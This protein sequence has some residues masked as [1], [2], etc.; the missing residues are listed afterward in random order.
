MKTDLVLRNRFEDQLSYTKHFGITCAH[1]TIPVCDISL[2][3]HRMKQPDIEE[4]HKNYPL[5]NLYD[6]MWH[7]SEYPLHDHSECHDPLVFT[8]LQ[9]DYDHCMIQGSTCC[10]SFGNITNQYLEVESPR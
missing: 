9:Y 6:S 8:N 10:D 3:K 5:D 7:H 2:L 1:R 4:I